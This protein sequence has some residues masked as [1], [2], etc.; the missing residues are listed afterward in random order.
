MVEYKDLTE[1]EGYL[2]L[3]SVIPT[4]LIDSINSKLDTLRMVRAS[5]AG[6]TYA[7]RE[8]IKDLPDVSVWWSQT[9]MDWPEVKLINDYLITR[10]NKE[11]DNAILYSSDI[12]TINGNT[13][14]VNPHVDTPHRF[15]QWNT[16][17][18]LL[19]VQCIVSLQDT[20]HEMGSTGFVP[21]SHEADW[22]ID[23]S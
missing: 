14:L 5:S 18:R 21:N 2:F 16:D 6:K 15:K 13:N 17:T 23:L 12:I 8:K 20:T 4:D 1:G 19:G 11:L 9:V 22:D 7:E 3:E 10:V